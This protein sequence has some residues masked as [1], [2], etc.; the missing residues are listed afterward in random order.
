MCNNGSDYFAGFESEFNDEV[1]K[2]YLIFKRQMKEI[3]DEFTGE[4]T[5]DNKTIPIFNENINRI[6]KD[7]LKDLIK[8]KSYNNIGNNENEM[9]KV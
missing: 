6:I 5:T 7:N 8:F 2:L 3:N 4:R 1:L 9:Q